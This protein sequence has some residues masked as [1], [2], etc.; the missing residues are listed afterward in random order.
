MG[1]INKANLQNNT[2]KDSIQT[3]NRDKQRK[4]ASQPFNT[5]R[6]ITSSNKIFGNHF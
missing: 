4:V 1:D 6:R 3:T 5:F 2:V